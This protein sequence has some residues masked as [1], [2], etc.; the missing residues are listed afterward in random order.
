MSFLSHIDLIHQNNRVKYNIPETNRTFRSYIPITFPAQS[1][2][3]CFLIQK[4]T[5]SK[6]LIL[7]G[8]QRV[9]LSDNNIISTI[10]HME[11]SDIRWFVDQLIRL[12]QAKGTPFEF[13][14]DG[15][16]YSFQGIE[17]YHSSKVITLFSDT[18]IQVQDLVLVM[19]FVFAKDYC[20]EH[21]PIPENTSKKAKSRKDFSKRTLC[22]YISLIDYYTWKSPRS[23]DFLQAI[24][25][26]TDNESLVEVPKEEK[27]F[28]NTELFDISLYL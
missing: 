5:L 26:P 2:S 7:D 1:S 8:A 11:E 12:Y 20:W 22:K 23:L 17:N 15:Q 24:G 3:V 25:Y 28:K 4:A 9:Y 21:M 14:I 6:L 10:M 27:M 16:Q 19:N 18:H 13:I